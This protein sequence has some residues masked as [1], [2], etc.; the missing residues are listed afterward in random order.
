MATSMNWTGN[1]VLDPPAARSTG[2]QY[3]ATLPVQGR[4][5][6][7]AVPPTDDTVQ[8]PPPSTEPGFIPYFLTQNIGKSVRAEFIVGSNQYIDKSGVLTEVGINYF[9]LSDPSVGTETMCDLY[10]VKFVTILRE[11]GR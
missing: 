6:M 9:V 5:T 2:Q 10:S 4:T 7:P 1:R 8:G 11:R 3:T